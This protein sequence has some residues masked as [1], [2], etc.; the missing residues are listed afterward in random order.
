MLLNNAP[1]AT[2]VVTTGGLFMIKL[3]KMCFLLIL[4]ICLGFYCRISVASEEDLFEK[5]RLKMVD[6]IVEVLIKNEICKEPKKGCKGMDFFAIPMSGGFYI[7]TYGI[8]DMQTLNELASKV[9]ALY[10]SNGT[11]RINMYSYSITKEESESNFFLI[12]IPFLKL[13]LKR[14]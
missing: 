13:E 10:A 4:A 12:D 1:T 8:T 5:E 11:I 9:L 3:H 14:N 7:A 2:G 6:E